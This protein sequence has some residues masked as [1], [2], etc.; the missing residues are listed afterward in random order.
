[1]TAPLRAFPGFWQGSGAT[2]GSTG[3]GSR[4]RVEPT[5][6]P[7][8]PCRGGEPLV[9]QRNFESALPPCRTARLSTAMRASPRPPFRAALL[10]SRL[11]GPALWRQARMTSLL[12]VALDMTP[13]THNS[14]RTA[15]ATNAPTALHTPAALTH[16]PPRPAAAPQ[17]PGGALDNADRISTIRP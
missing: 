14:R 6:G 8:P 5:R 9:E 10:A 11:G 3:R 17:K 4:P 2:I 12:R 7:L 1:M 15:Y 16:A 13:P